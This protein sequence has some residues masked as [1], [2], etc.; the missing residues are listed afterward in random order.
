MN[1]KLWRT[2]NSL[3]VMDV[4]AW[5][6]VKERTHLYLSFLSQSIVEVLLKQFGDLT[7]TAVEDVNEYL[8]KTYTPKV[9]VTTKIMELQRFC[10][11]EHESIPIFHTSCLAKVKSF[12]AICSSR[13]VVEVC[14]QIAGCYSSD[15]LR[16]KALAYLEEKLTNK[17]TVVISEFT[18]N[19][20]FHA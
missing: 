20:E 8:E 10:K 7:V 17:A 5:Y 3:A 18:E 15:R 1:F 19:M 6:K 13:N 4:M 12:E 11:Q 2:T 9:A 16:E 14:L